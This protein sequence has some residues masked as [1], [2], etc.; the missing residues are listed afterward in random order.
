LLFA[1]FYL[2]AFSEGTASKLLGFLLLIIGPMFQLLL[3]GTQ[4]LAFRDIFGLDEV[5]A[6]P[7]SQ[8]G[9]QLVA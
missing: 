1:S 2:S 6:G 3:F 4:Y 9:D 7:A 8:S 5:A